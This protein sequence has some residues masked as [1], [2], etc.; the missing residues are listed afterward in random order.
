MPGGAAGD[1]KFGF[2]VGLGVSLALL[3]WSLVQMFVGK[4]VK[5]SG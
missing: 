4:A 5:G 3:V 2:W 1:I